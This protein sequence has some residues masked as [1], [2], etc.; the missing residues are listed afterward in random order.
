VGR[1]A[2]RNE[3]EDRF[4]ADR[5]LGATPARVSYG[6]DAACYSLTARFGSAEGCSGGN[7]SCVHSM[8]NDLGSASAAMSCPWASPERQRN[9]ASRSE[10]PRFQ[11]MSSGF[12]A[13]PC[14]PPRLGANFLVPP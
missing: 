13:N 5:F 7:R 6:V 9:S 4:V 3:V 12:G 1:R 10:G 8:V 11:R 2:S 14:S